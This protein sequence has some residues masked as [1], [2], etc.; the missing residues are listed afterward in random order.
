[1]KRILVIFSV[2]MTLLS[3]STAFAE[4]QGAKLQS[5]A[6]GWYH[7]NVIFTKGQLTEIN[8]GSVRVEGEGGY[9]DI[10]LNLSATTH[11]VN[12]EDGMPVPFSALYKGESVV[13]YYG[14]GVSKSMPP[15]GNAFALVVGTPAKG[16]AGIYMKV[17]SIEKVEDGRIKALSSNGDRLITISSE[18]FPQ[19]TAIREGSEMLVW[20]DMMTL[21]IPGQA[22]ATKAVLLPVTMKVHLGAGVIV[23]NGKELVLGQDDR[24][25]V[26]GKTVLL[27]LRVIAENLGYSI[28][29]QA[30]QKQ[31]ELKHGAE[32]LAALRIGSNSYQKGQ[33]VVGLA[34][35]PELVNGKTL[36]P[37]EFF[38][39]V[40]NMKVSVSNTH[41]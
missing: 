6:A 31:I 19:L 12:A 40:L 37:V 32:S 14:P 35:A 4:G 17:G 38:T 30:E 27:P 25:I 28:A 15:Q 2:L 21:S 11:I 36:V 18:V 29:W 8:D 26:R 23:A 34:T 33:D 20:Y 10:V 9:R 24:I 7:N 3:F 16:A 5:S 41:I 39:D 1:M 22:A 13:A